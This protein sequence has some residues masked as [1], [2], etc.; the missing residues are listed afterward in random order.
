M[1]AATFTPKINTATKLKNA[2]HRTAMK[3][4]RTFVDT[5]VAIEFA[6]SF[7]PFKKS[8]NRAITI[9]IIIIASIIVS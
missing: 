8:N 3:G 2:A 7:M 4:G 1:V 5:T 6:A 9:V